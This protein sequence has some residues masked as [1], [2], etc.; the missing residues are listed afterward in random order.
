MVIVMIILSTLALIGRGVYSKQIRNANYSATE[1]SQELLAMSFDIIIGQNNM[2]I[3]ASDDT[4]RLNKITIYLLDIE[5]DYL[6]FA[7]D[8][9]TL[10]VLQNGFLVKSQ[11]MRDA[12]NMPF[13][14]YFSTLESDKRILIISFGGDTKN[15]FSTYSQGDFK[16]DIVTIIKER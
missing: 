9:S 7:F 1:K 2:P 14:F 4:D 12:F 3:I 5:E 8:Y 15:D 11:D 10:E 16:D 6:D 13:L